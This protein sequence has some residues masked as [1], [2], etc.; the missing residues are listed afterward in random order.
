MV[1]P[2]SSTE[3]LHITVTAPAGTDLTGTPVQ[4]AVV[5]HRDN[6][7]GA[8]W[9]TAEW[10]DGAARLLVGPEGG[11]LTLS[12]GDYHVWIH[13]DPPGVEVIVRKSGIVSVA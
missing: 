5:A 11:A 3:F 1:I 7:S 8:E 4:I 13:I 12:H 10:T 6:P 2:A 9:K